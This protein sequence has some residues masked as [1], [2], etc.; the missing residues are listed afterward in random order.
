MGANNCNFTAGDL[1]NSTSQLPYPK[2]S[3]IK[4]GGG[5]GGGRN[6]QFFDSLNEEFKTIEK[7]ELL[8]FL[9]YAL[10]L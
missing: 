3:C 5:G 10:C 2:A 9:K 1:W 6:V 4:T 8:M 7:L